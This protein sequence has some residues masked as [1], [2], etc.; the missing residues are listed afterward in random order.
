[1]IFKIWESR[2]ILQHSIFIHIFIK[3]EFFNYVESLEPFME[4]KSTAKIKEVELQQNVL[5]KV[6]ED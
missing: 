5:S 1:M 2:I 6:K 4:S 3:D